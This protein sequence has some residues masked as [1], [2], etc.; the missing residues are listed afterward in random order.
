MPIPETRLIRLADADNVVLLTTSIAR[1]E[2]VTVEGLDVALE[3]DL[4]LG[5]K[6]AARDIAAGE[7][8][9]KYAFPIGVA[10]VDIPKGAHVHVQNVRSNHTASYVVSEDG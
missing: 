6:L 9:T 4:T 2:V 7:T 8:I 5:H 3:A 10:T 1:G